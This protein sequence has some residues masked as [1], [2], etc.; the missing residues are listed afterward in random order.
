MPCHP[1]KKGT[2]RESSG[3]GP[4][5][6]T[7]H[8]GIDFAA[9]I[10]TPIYA[11]AD[12]IVV[13]GR[14]RYGVSGFGSWIWLDCQK[15]V[16]KDFI[17]GHVKHSGILVKAGDRVKAGQ[18]IGVVGNEGQSTGPHL[19]FE[20][21][22]SP[23]RIGGRHEDPAGWLRNKPHPDRNSPPEKERDPVSTPIYGI[24][25]S[26]W[27]RGINLTAVK[28]EGF[29]FAI[30]KITEGTT[31]I[32]PSAKPQLDQ[33]QRAG[34][35]VAQY[36]FLTRGSVRA[37]A[38][39]IRRNANG[40][41]PIAIDFEHNP[42]NGT[43]PTWADAVMLRDLLKPHFPSVGI[44][45]NEADWRKAGAQAFTGWS[46]VWK[47]KYAYAQGGFASEVYNLA[48]T[49]GW[50][51]MNGCT[52]DLW[53]F[54]DKAR[55]A[56]MN[57]DANAFRGTLQQLRALW[58]PGKNAPVRK[59]PQKETNMELQL[60]LDQLAGADR[61]NGRPTFKG[62]NLETVLNAARKK[63]NESLTLV[64]ICAVTYQRTI[65]LEKKVDQLT[66]LLK[67]NR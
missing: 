50:N 54:T 10:G 41:L 58:H 61:K 37:Q 24:D 39:H 49:W 62:W 23:G 15:S 19:H 55:V 48:P 56:G 63:R 21:W 67:E 47:A 66:D 45:T 26:N 33:A 46:W 53:Q 7:F 3:Y 4:R 14:D 40:S 42:E 34:L 28:K 8:A 17:Y 31:Y 2:Y 5:W 27:Q 16:G 22:G 57:V 1:M 20:V 12:G 65:E 43:L 32:S 30:I 11:V 44:Y 29:A 18:Q 13:E 51:P 38:D 35:L 25:I 9:P 52:P 59:T 6:G 64:E 36:H 60:I